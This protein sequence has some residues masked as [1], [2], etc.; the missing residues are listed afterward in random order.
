MYHEKSNKKQS[1][2]LSALQHLGNFRFLS[3]DPWPW[4]NGFQGEC[5]KNNYF[6]DN[7]WV[8]FRDFC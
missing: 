6:T 2:F 3:L 5:L 7:S 1:D 4:G 8:K